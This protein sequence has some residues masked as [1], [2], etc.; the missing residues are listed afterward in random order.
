M[1]KKIHAAEQAAE[2]RQND[3]KM[4]EIGRKMTEKR[5]KNDKN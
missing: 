5:S 2:E 4:T 3:T 1:K